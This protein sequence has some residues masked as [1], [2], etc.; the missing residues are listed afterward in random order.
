MFY[1]FF[2]FFFQT[3]SDFSSVKGDETPTRNR[4]RTSSISSMTSENS[5][6][7]N[8]SFSHSYYVPSDVESE[9]EEASVNLSSVSKE[10]LYA[11]VKRFERRAFKYKSKFMEVCLI[12]FLHTFV[13]FDVC[14]IVFGV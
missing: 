3:A 10:D 5:F 9:M 12:F 11:F 6:F 4:S 1:D 13:V 2:P 14:R 8:V 7:P